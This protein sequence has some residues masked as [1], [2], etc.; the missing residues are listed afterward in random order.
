MTTCS[1]ESRDRPVIAIIGGGVSG[2]AV[3]FHLLRSQALQPGQ[4]FIFEPRTRLGAG[5]AYDT[6]DPAHRINVPAAKMSLFPDDPEHF[7]RWLQ[8]GNALEGDRTAVAANGGL[9]PRRGLFGRYI[10]SMVQPFIDSGAITHVAER[11]VDVRRL[12]GGWVIAGEAG[13]R[14][15]ADI[16]VIATSHPS[17][18]PPQALQNALAD[19][20]RFVVDPTRP[21]ALD[22]IRAGDRVLVVGNGLTSADVIA[23]L[24]LR[25]HKGPITAISRRGLRS[26]G[27][28]P[29]K[30]ELFGDFVSHPS[31]TAVDLLRRVRAAIREAEGEGRS[32]H[33]VIDQVRAQGQHLWRAMPVNERRR[34]VRHL[35][36]FWDVHR[37]RVAPQVETVSEEAIRAGRLKVFAASVASVEA[38]GEV[39]DCTLR[40]SRS[41][42]ILN[43][44]FD[45]V[46][47]TTGPGHRGILSSQGW[48]G[49]LADAGYLAIDATRLGLACNMVSQAL[50]AGGKAAPSLFISGPL[51]RGTFGEL[52]GLPEV[53]E[54]AVFVAAQVA[55]E[56]ADYTKRKQGKPKLD[57]SAA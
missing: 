28:A 35:R 6:H 16:L 26:R 3:A 22:A 38:K 54:H 31:R 15:E 36:P 48:I 40:L 2:T 46:V 4:L 18:L 55:S 44:E 10:G 42:E 47:V 37:F 7:Q 49:A 25:G 19:H 50:G 53:I 23:S 39:I 13:R 52:M 12:D 17:P 41:G 1:H 27:H 20:P 24:D 56:V 34:V 29:I 51:A 45:A 30:Q 8:E 9:F 57:S 21:D 5:L 14:V 32:W 43:C 11:A 33:A